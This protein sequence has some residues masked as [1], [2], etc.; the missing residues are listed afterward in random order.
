MTATLQIVLTR[1]PSV[2][3]VQFDAATAV[4]PL[5]VVK[6]QFVV[7]KLASVVVPG[8]HETTGA[9]ASMMSVRHSV[10]T[11][12]GEVPALSSVH[13]DGVQDETICF[14]QT[15]PGPAEQV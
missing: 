8:A 2:P 3:C 12:F 14:S 5:R 10:L 4:G 15:T 1:L 9:T 6:A 13:D 11:K 7:T